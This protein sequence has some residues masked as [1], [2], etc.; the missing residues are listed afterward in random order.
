MAKKFFEDSDIPWASF[1][2]FRR[3]A[4]TVN[5]KAPPEEE[6]DD[7]DQVP[8]LDETLTGMDYIPYTQ[9]NAEEFFAQLEQWNDEDEYTRCIPGPGTP[10]R[11]TG[12]TT[13]PPTPWHGRW[14]T[15]P[16]S[17]T[18]TRAP[19]TIK[20]DKALRRAIEVLESV[21]EEGQDKAEWNMRMAY[22][23]QYLYA[24]GGKGHPLRPA[25]GR[26]GP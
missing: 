26:A 21:R 12:G 1:H 8:E 24:S 16:S 19:L 9:Q 3:E 20:G 11:R 5:L 13:A 14:R 2:T 17:G 25:V 6:Q 10:S 18:T 4:G 22:G 15:T 7:E 23:Y